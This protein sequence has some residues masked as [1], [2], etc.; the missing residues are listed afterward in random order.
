[1]AA[2]AASLHYH[3]VS[4]VRESSIVTR[5]IYSQPY[6]TSLTLPPV[7]VCARNL[8][9]LSPS[10]N[11]II[12]STSLLCDPYSMGRYGKGPVLKGSSI[13]KLRFCKFK[14]T[15]YNRK[16]S[17][18]RNSV[19]ETPS[20]YGQN[21]E[22]YP[23]VKRKQEGDWDT[24]GQKSLTGSLLSKALSVFIRSQVERCDD[25][26]VRVHGGNRELLSGHIQSA[27]LGAS[28]TVFRGLA[29]TS[30]DVVAWSILLS[31]GKS[32]MTTGKGL[33][34]QPFEVQARISL[35]QHDLSASLSS[36][37]L[38]SAIRDL[39][40]LPSSTA[41]PRFEVAL[42]NGSLI[43]T[44][45]SQSFSNA[46]PL[47]LEFNVSSNGRLLS[48]KPVS[49]GGMKGPWGWGGGGKGIPPKQFDLGPGTNITRLS[50]CPDELRVE[51]TFT[52]TP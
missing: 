51:G 10:E 20:T 38:S 1:M 44:T 22:A 30:V 4:T 24:G 46:F 29:L 7:K 12:F 3:A 11:P 23:E 31:L 43:I 28:N 49:T 50:I 35:T 16:P 6:P 37:L 8:L 14:K 15:K 19:E 45:P 18:C 25:L 48:A 33:I 34:R 21:Q 27:S 13:G 52:V 32:S 42:Q 36:Q 41:V 47:A 5:S 26:K 9:T 40:S 39:L 17:L 2:F